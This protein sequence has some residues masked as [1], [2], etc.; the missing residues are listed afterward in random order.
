MLER[1]VFF[2]IYLVANI[3]AAIIYFFSGV[4]GGDLRGYELRYP[5]MMLVALFILMLS[6]YFL[7][8]LLYPILESF[9]KVKRISTSKNYF[10]LD[11]FFIFLNLSFG[12]FS[13]KYD[14]GIAGVDIDKGVPK[15][16][17]YFFIVM[18]PIFLTYIYLAYTSDQKRK[19]FYVNAIILML[20]SV[21]KGWLSSFIYL[22]YIF[23]M[24]NN[25]FI[26]KYKIKFLSVF[27]LGV[28]LSPF[29]KFFKSVVSTVN[30]S[31]NGASY[32]DAI[33]AVMYY[34]DINSISD[35]FKIYL[36]STIERFEHVS[37]IYFGLIENKIDD[38]VNSVRITPFFAEGWIQ[39]RVY[40]IFSLSKTTDL[41]LVLAQAIHGAYSWRIN[42]PISLWMIV[43]SNQLLLILFY[44]IFLVTLTILL[45]KLLSRQVVS[46]SWI[47]VLIMLLHGWFYS[48]SLYIQALVMF[49]LIIL[50]IRI[51]KGLKNGL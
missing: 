8:C 39:N 38:I 33:N 18:Q 45:S 48:F 6:M 25:D 37:I 42:T 41:Q 20:F 29:L 49:I 10:T 51:M 30:N 17:L 26:L 15:M 31:Q 40:E 34:R 2:R 35:L 12:L 14:I 24:L 7:L 4:V 28:M 23:I 19:L 47:T 16:P 44:I 46:F 43:E 50:C 11:V 3:I 36:L 27:I 9:I 21:L 22:A 5:A 13:L 32:T 1:K